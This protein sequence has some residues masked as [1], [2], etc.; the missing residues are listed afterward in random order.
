[1]TK[2]FPKKIPLSGTQG[3]GYFVRQQDDYSC[4]PACLATVA[5]IFGLTGASYDFCRAA[6]R[7]DPAVGTPSAHMHALSRRF[8]PFESEGC[9]TY[10][11]GVAI[12]NIVQE[13]EDHYVVLLCREDDK[14]LYYDP[15]Y[16][17]LVIDKTQ[18]LPWVS[19]TEDKPA[20][21]INFSPLACNT[22]ETWLA[23]AQPAHAHNDNAPAPAKRRAPPFKP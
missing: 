22:F 9:G 16:H 3:D 14:I 10:H 13:K 1:M 6:A 20:W 12:A 19:L 2:N 11:G 17:E 18:N 8:L 21:S 5:N 23:K 7:P 4:G 15:Y